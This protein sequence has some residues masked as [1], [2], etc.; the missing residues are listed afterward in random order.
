MD[1]IS[2]SH[3]TKTCLYKFKTSLLY[4]TTG[5]HRGGVYTC[6][7]FF[8]ISAQKLRLWVRVREAVLTSTHDLCFEQKYE[9]YQIFLSEN[10]HFSVVKFSVYLNR[11]VLVVKKKIFQAL[12]LP[13]AIHA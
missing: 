3:I 4:S 12:L 1:S 6:F 2:Y 9:K 11:Y 5:V 7:F 8:F 10:F 13:I